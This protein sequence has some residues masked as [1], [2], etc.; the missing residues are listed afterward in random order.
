MSERS[1]LATPQE[2]ADYLGVP[3]R[4]VDSWR[5]RGVGP[6]YVKVG[7]HVRYDWRDLE[8]WQA[9]QTQETAA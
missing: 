4:T 2:V 8:A 7:R 5:Y 3:L 1:A 9:Q 6:R